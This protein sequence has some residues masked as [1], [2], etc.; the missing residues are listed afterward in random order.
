MTASGWCAAPPRYSLIQAHSPAPLLSRSLEALIC[1]R[2]DLITI[3]SIQCIAIPGTAYRPAPAAT[4]PHPPSP[5]VCVLVPV[6][7]AR[8]RSLAFDLRCL[9]GVH[10][11]FSPSCVDIMTMR[12]TL[13]FDQVFHSRHIVHVR[14]TVELSTEDGEQTPLSTFVDAST[15]QPIGASDKSQSG[16]G[17]H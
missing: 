3:C 13:S 9:I 6:A 17:A 8:R 14:L 12:N 4:Y 10:T 7:A 11:S 5:F 16:F 1:A 15:L 2:L